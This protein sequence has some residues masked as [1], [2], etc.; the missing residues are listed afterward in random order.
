MLSNELLQWLFRVLQAY[1][2]PRATYHDV[3]VLLQRFPTLRPR[4]RVYTYES[5]RSALLLNL[6][7]SLPA[8]I[9][10]HVYRIPVELWLPHEYPLEPPLAYVTP[11]DT[12]VLQPGTH[13]DTSGKCYLPYL[14]HWAAAVDGSPGNIAALCD[15][16]CT[17]F[18]KESPVFAKPAGYQA[19]TPHTPQTPQTSGPTLPPK[20]QTPTQP[21]I[22]SPIPTHTSRDISTPPPLPPLP[23]ELRAQLA[24]SPTLDK[25]AEQS[26]LTRPAFEQPNILDELAEVANNDNTERHSAISRLE[27]VLQT[28]YTGEVAKEL[29]SLHLSTREIKY[30]IGKFAKIFEYEYDTLDQ[31][32]KHILGNKAILSRCIAEAQ[33]TIDEASKIREIDVDEM[34]V[35]ETVVYNQ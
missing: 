7:G 27:N 15:E 17:V 13:V 28:I 25:M 24:K 8:R 4:T 6:Y 35:A 23:H 16:L 19:Q 29:E 5:G 22:V 11:T 1:E 33:Q 3:A 18:G 2:D 10:D 21:K 20:Q 30:A 12:M 26:L 14:A 32:N 34:V 31:T 9:N